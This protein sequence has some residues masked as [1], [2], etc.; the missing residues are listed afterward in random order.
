MANDADGIGGGGEEQNGANR[1]TT[2]EALPDAVVDPHGLGA[3]A[4]DD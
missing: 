3:S 4:R 1:K 2:D